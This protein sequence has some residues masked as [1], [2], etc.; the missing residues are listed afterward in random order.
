M[1]CEEI[2]KENYAGTKHIMV[3]YK[4]IIVSPLQPFRRNYCLFSKINL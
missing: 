4:C 3:W 1:D 2:P